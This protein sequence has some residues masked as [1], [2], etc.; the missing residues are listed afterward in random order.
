MQSQKLISS[1]HACTLGGL[2]NPL[3]WPHPT[4][5]PVTMAVGETSGLTK[6]LGIPAPSGQYTV[7]CVDLMHK[8]E[9]DDDGLLVRLYYPT[10]PQIQAEVTTGYQYV[11]WTPHERY[12]EAFLD[13]YKMRLPGFLTDVVSG[14]AMLLLLFSLSLR[15]FIL[16]C[17]STL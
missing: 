12:I 17:V 3:I 9:G 8:L 2:A 1:A 11:K 15:L 10:T 16:L 5:S 13:Y 6:G 14:R 7:G 4:S